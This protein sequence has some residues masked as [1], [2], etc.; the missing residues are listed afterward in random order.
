MA[1]RTKKRKP[2]MGSAEELINRAWSFLADAPC[3]GYFGEEKEYRDLVDDLA[4][5]SEPPIGK[6]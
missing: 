1:K 3:E 6:Y 4:S 5:Y 2:Y